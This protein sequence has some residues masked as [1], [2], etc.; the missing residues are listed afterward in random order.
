MDSRPRPADFA[1]FIS[2]DIL[3]T[4]NT[5]KLAALLAAQC[6][7][8]AVCPIYYAMVFHCLISAKSPIQTWAPLLGATW[9]QPR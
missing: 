8:R 6:K 4:Y 5:E 7:E 2:A 9:S 3:N 1:F